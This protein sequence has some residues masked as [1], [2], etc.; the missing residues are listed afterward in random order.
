MLDDDADIVIDEEEEEIRTGDN[1]DENA[2]SDEMV[3]EDEGSEGEDIQTTMENTYYSA[4][5]SVNTD[6]DEAIEMF[7]L[8]L[9]MEEEK[10][11][12]G[13]K[14]LKQIIKAYFK[15]GKYNEMVEKYK[16]LLSYMNVVS[17]NDSEKAIN[18]ILSLVST[19]TDQKLLSNIYQITLDA[20]KEANNEKLWFNTK[21]KQGKVF[22]DMKDYDKL[23]TC[24]D[25]LKEW[26]MNEEGREDSKKSSQLLDVYVL[27]IQMYSE[28][29]E[30]KKLESLYKK[31][32]NLSSGAVVLNPRVTGIIREC[33]GKMYMRDKKWALAHEDL[34][35]AFK[36]YDEAGN[37]RRI[38]CLK[39]LVL[40]NMLMG[41]NINP[42]DANEVKPYKQHPEITAMT[43]LVEAY[44]KSDIKRFEKILRENKQSILEDSF[45]KYYIDDL[46]TNI[47]T[48]V[49][50]ILITPYTRIRM[51]F[52][53]R[54]LNIDVPLVEKL[55]VDLILDQRLDAYIDQIN[56]MIQLKSKGTTASRYRSI[57]QW[58]TKLGDIHS[59]IVNKVN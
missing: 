29:E 27:E 22:F 10:G 45:I 34:F 23:Q 49:L 4:K 48:K 24:I 58:A 5:G 8:V 18:N 31:C 36:S 56:E 25:E 1:G 47:R 57:H 59:A 50:L 17:R 39:Y 28:R 32:I 15:H 2:G 41:S 21:L 40:A 35:E 37:P 14:T 30:L 43:D 54:E 42:F 6:L 20:L 26:C 51:S 3:D 33:G 7:N 53:A 9:D 13:F 55:C 52:I 16:Q 44:Q 38:Q 46:L 12:W 11:N 19:S